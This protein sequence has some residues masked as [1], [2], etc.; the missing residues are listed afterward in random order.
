MDNISVDE[1]IES[2]Q[3]RWDNFSSNHEVY[4]DMFHIEGRVI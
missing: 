3:E 4:P 2:H 1:W